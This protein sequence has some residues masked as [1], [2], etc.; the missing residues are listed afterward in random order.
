MRPSKGPPPTPSNRP[1]ADA[2]ALAAAQGAPPASPT[3]AAASGRA[4]TF[5]GAGDKRAS[6][7]GRSHNVEGYPSPE[8]KKPS[9]SASARGFYAQSPAQ[10][11]HFPRRG[12]VDRRAG[13]SSGPGGGAGVEVADV[14]TAEDAGGEGAGGAAGDANGM[15]GECVGPPTIAHAILELAA[16]A[17]EV[18]AIA[19]APFASEAVAAAEAGTG[20]GAVASPSDE[21]S[22]ASVLWRCTPGRDSSANGRCIVPEPE[23]RATVHPRNS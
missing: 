2:D 5:A 21:R 4:L 11:V 16:E 6:Q 13:L 9:S 23:A 8:K 22:V 17:A 18:A 14:S 3:A 20:A 7:E 12:S 15:D 1:G 19:A 10:S